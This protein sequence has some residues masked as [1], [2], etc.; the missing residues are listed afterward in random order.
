MKCPRCGKE[1]TGSMYCLNCG[2][3]IRSYDEAVKLERQIQY[4]RDNK[5]SISRPSLNKS[6]LDKFSLSKH[7]PII[8]ILIASAIIIVMLIPY[9]FKSTPQPSAIPTAAQQ[10]NIQKQQ[11]IKQQQNEQAKAEAAIYK[12]KLISSIDAVNNLFVNGNYYSPVYAGIS[13]KNGTLILKVNNRWDYLPANAKKGF[14]KAAFVSFFTAAKSRK[15]DIDSST[16]HLSV[17]ST[18]S[19]DEVASWGPIMGTSIE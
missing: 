12:N 9:I 14:V 4:E 19:G 10:E 6:H 16:F 13:F 1:V 5:S 2:L 3:R 18:L 8:A 7:R 15:L 11:E 17:V